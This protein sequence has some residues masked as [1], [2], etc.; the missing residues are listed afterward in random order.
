MIL[1]YYIDEIRL[2]L[3]LDNSDAE[4]D[5]RIITRWL[6]SQRALFIK[7]E[8][9]KGNPLTHSAY[10]TING[11]PLTLVSGRM[12]LTYDSKQSYLTTVSKLPRIMEVKGSLLIRSLRLPE[13]GGKELNIELPEKI[14][15]TGKGVFN[16]NELYAT[17]YKDRVYVKNT[18]DSLV[19]TSLNDITIDAIFENPLELINF[20]DSNGNAAYNVDRDHYPINDTLWEYI[21]GAIRNNRYLLLNQ[22]KENEVNDDRDNT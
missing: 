13:L 11:L 19:S 17:Y 15:Y 5:D 18:E 20:V 4:I 3:K 6:N 9:N 8:V 2:T 12:V 14:E 21:L 22:I 16:K 7:N 1:K 10:Q